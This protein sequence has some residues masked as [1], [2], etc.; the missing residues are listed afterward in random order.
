[1]GYKNA[2]IVDPEGLS[3]GLALFWKDS[4]NVEILFSDSRIIDAKVKLGSLIF[5]ISCVY[6]DPVAHLRQIVWDKLIDISVL[7][8]DPWLVLGDL[9]EIMNNSEKLGGPARVESS[10]YGI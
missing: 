2:H 6:G 3:G 7:R 9:N 8:N 10:F 4:Y 1:M 5:Y